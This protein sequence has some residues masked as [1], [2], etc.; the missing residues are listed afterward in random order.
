[1]PAHVPPARARVQHLQLRRTKLLLRTSLMVKLAPTMK[2]AVLLALALVLSSSPSLVEASV[3]SPSSRHRRRRR[4]APAVRRAEGVDWRAAYA[5]RGCEARRG[6]RG[7]PLWR[8]AGGLWVSPRQVKPGKQAGGG[9]APNWKGGRGGGGTTEQNDRG[10]IRGKQ[11]DPPGS[12]DGT[13]RT[14][15][16]MHGN[17]NGRW[18]GV[19]CGALRVS[20]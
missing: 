6:R 8:V 5:A 10:Q 14:D 13:H 11:G 18:G 17:G 12:G 15:L 20:S 1:M 3:R 2:Q 19:V 4:A 16:R 9:R 7:P